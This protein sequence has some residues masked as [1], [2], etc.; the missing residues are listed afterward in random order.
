MK[1]IP[2][3]CGF[4]FTDKSLET[5]QYIL[6]LQIAKRFEEPPKE[7]QKSNCMIFLGYTS[8]LISSGVRETIRYLAQHSMVRYVNNK[9]YFEA[10][11]G[12]VFIHLGATEYIEYYIKNKGNRAM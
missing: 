12:Y 10:P 4:K 9:Y 8:N 3:K 11:R 5:A 2:V 7:G 1:F 6:I